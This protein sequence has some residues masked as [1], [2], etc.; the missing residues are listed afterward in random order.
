MKK[1]NKPLALF[2][3]VVFL[4]SLTACGGGGSGGSSARNREPRPETKEING[5]VYTLNPLLTYDDIELTYFHF[6]QDE[7]VKYLA[8]RFME[9]YPNI[10]VITRYENVISYSDILLAMIANGQSPDLMMQTDCDFVLS[11]MLALDIKEFW[12]EDPETY[13]LADTIRE[14]GLGTFYVD[15]QFAVPVKF[16]PPGFFIDLNVLET[17]NLTAPTRRWTWDEMIQ[18]IKDATVLD[19]PTGMA[20]YGLGYDNRLESFYGV[21]AGQEYI[22]EFGFNGKTFDLGVYAIGG[23]QFAD[24]KLGGYVA[25][26]PET[27]ANEDWTGDWETWYGATGHVAV[28]SESF[29]TFQNLWNTEGFKQFNLDIVP[30]PVPAVRKEDAVAGTHNSIAI[31]DFGNVTTSCKHPREAY[32]L[33]KFMGFGIDGWKTRLELY[34]NESITNPSGLP[35]RLDVMPMPITKDEYIQAEY[36]KIYT[37]G[38]APEYVEHWREFFTSS[39]RPIPYGWRAIPGY[40]NFCDQYFNKI[41]IH[42]LVDSGKAKAADFVVEGTEQANKFHAEAMIDYFGPNGYNILS[43]EQIAEY[44]ALIDAAN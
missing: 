42:G 34:N 41:G 35:L 8:E 16:F 5:I 6:D 7:T 36:L 13:N 24:L 3:T 17:L 31:I 26:R 20:F 43:P 27:Q 15:A 23:Q 18:L 28:F 11:N 25:P 29:W 4:F 14:A 12:D 38:M 30:Y 33:L 22:G 10:K 9:L 2:L 21:A 1:I 40:W 37:K 44:Q 39:M 32:E 19:S